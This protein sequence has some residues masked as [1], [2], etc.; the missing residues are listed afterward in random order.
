[1]VWIFYPW[2]LVRLIS[3]WDWSE[4]VPHESSWRT[5]HSS[6]IFL[7]PCAPFWFYPHYLHR[8]HICGRFQRYGSRF[9]CFGSQKPEA[10][11][12]ISATL[13][14]LRLSIFA[15]ACLILSGDLIG[16]SFSN[17]LYFCI[18]MCS[19]LTQILVPS[20]GL[21]KMFTERLFC[22]HIC[23]SLVM[24]AGTYSIVTVG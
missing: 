3:M 22:S 21:N 4:G 12:N 20:L 10:S 23:H 8:S 17:G 9:S 18:M 13:P 1:M 16:Y 7:E 14:G 11:T 19:K 2:D 5:Y 15:I 24:D 6:L